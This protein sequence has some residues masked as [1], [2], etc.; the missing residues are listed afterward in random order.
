MKRH[1][2]GPGQTKL[3]LLGPIN[4]VDRLRG[5]GL[6]RSSSGPRPPLRLYRSV[7]IISVFLS[8]SFS[9]VPFHT[10]D[11]NFHASSIYSIKTEIPNCKA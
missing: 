8:L 4:G 3:P 6:D 11:F 5:P 10:E 7:V 2:Y 9:L 1:R